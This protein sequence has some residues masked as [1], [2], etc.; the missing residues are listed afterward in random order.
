[1]LASFHPSL[2]LS[3]P[4]RFIAL[5]VHLSATMVIFYTQEFHL[6]STQEHILFLTLLSASLVGFLIQF[7]GLISGLSVFYPGR[8]IYYASM[9]TFGAVFVCW[10]VTEAWS[11]FTY[12]Y[13]FFVFHFIPTM[14]ELS[15]IMYHVV[16]KMQLWRRSTTCFVQVH[17]VSTRRW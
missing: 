13:L 6:L 14:V 2:R 5:L 9:H 17:D 11:Y 8:N 15:T 3:L 1:M 12:V 4:W 10:F 16:I 7:V